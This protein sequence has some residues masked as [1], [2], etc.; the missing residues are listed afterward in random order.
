M[1]PTVLTSGALPVATVKFTAT[2]KG[3][4]IFRPAAIISSNMMRSLAGASTSTRQRGSKG[5]PSTSSPGRMV[6]PQSP[7]IFTKLSP[8]SGI[9][10]RGT[11]ARAKKE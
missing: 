2:S 8:S 3:S 5:K 7:F 11:H 10:L 6:T 1:V 4:D 9:G